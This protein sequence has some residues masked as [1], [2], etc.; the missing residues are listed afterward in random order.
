MAEKKRS[1]FEDSVAIPQIMRKEQ[2]K[3]CNKWPRRSEADSRI[4]LQFRR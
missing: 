3:E 4:V 2:S 1:E